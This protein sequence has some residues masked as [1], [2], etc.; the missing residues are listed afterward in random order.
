MST[1]PKPFITAEQYLEIEKT[2]E[3]KSEYY[4][5]EMF[6]V[7][8]A[9]SDHNQISDNLSRVFGNEFLSRPCY[10]I[11]RDLRVRVSRTGPYTYP[12]AILVCGEREWADSSRSTLLNPTVIFEVLSDSTEAYDRGKKFHQYLQLPSLREYILVS[13]QDF[14]VDQFVLH[15]DGEWH[16]RSY[17]SLDAV[18]ELPSVGCSISLRDIY[19]KTDLMGN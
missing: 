1:Q 10:V 16:L 19:F 11:T 15:P 8:G 9:N 2:A 17:A 13:Q 7:A 14:H 5:G 3:C 18:V 6:L 12:D 4:N